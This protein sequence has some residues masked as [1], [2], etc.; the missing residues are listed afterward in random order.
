[1]A[2]RHNDSLHKHKKKANKLK[3]LAILLLALL[4]ICVIVVGVDWLITKLSASNTVVGSVSNATVQSARINVFQ[5]PFYRFQ[6]NESWR[7]VTSQYNDPENEYIYRSYNNGLIEHELWITV[8]K[9]K[10]FDLEK[11]YPT[12]VLP[13]RIESDGRLTKLGTVSERCVTALPN[14]EQSNQDPQIVVQEEVSYFCYPNSTAFN[15]TIGVPGGTNE[16]IMPRNNGSN[17]PVTIIYKNVTAF[18]DTRQIELILDTFRT[19]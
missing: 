12:R 10:S 8:D 17:I 9:Q 1:M 14:G 6:A 4:T 2:Y 11:H 7:E 19:L 5:T 3:N 15:V 16:L 18:P 13:V